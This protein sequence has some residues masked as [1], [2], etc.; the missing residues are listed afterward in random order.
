VSESAQREQGQPRLAEQRRFPAAVRAAMAIAVLL[1]V[2]L[3]LGLCRLLPPLPDMQTPIARLTF[4]LKCSAVAVLLSLMTGIEA[5]AHERFQGDAFDPLAGHETERMKINLRYLQNTLE[6]TL[7]FIPGL[8]AL[9][10][11]CTDGRAMRAIVA[12][13][14]V[15]ILSRAAFW[16]GY[17]RGSRYRIVGLTGMLQSMLVLL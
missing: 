11:Y 14:A 17:H 15:W 9:A 2:G 6:Q 16:I 10:M 1:S 12:T 4:A 5:V 3:W 13:T 7:L 8:L